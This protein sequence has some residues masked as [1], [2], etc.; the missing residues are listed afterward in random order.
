MMLERFAMSLRYCRRLS[1]AD[2]PDDLN[3]KVRRNLCRAMMLIPIGFA[4]SA[5]LIGCGGLVSSTSPND[6]AVTHFGYTGS[7]LAATVVPPNN[8][9]AISG[10]YFGMTI[11]RLASNPTPSNPAVPFP[12]FPIH[13]FRFWDV[14][15]WTTLE[16]TNGQYD[17]TTMDS[18]IAIA[19][20]NGVSD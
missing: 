1:G 10:A 2:K 6:S 5:T 12:A 3:Q 15:N 8:S 20:Q 4:I 7:P 17:W 16:P 13:T 14:V 9:A 18:T 19:K 11:H